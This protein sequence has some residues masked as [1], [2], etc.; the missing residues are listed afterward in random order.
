MASVRPL[1]FPDSAE[2]FE[3]RR[4]AA[5]QSPLQA[6]KFIE[7]MTRS[8]RENHFGGSD[9]QWTE[10]LDKGRSI[11]KLLIDWTHRGPYH[12]VFGNLD[13][14]D[15]EHL[16][17]FGAPTV[18]AGARDALTLEKRAHAT[19]RAHKD[20]FPTSIW[21]CCR[22]FCFTSIAIDPDKILLFEE[23]RLIHE[24]AEQMHESINNESDLLERRERGIGCSTVGYVAPT[25]VRRENVLESQS[26]T[27]SKTALQNFANFVLKVLPFL[28]G[29][30]DAPS[31]TKCPSERLCTQ[32]IC[33]LLSVSRKFLYG[34]KKGLPSTEPSE[35]EL[36]SIVDAAGT[37]LRQHR[38]VGNR[39]GYPSILE[40]P[41]YDCGCSEPC[42]GGLNVV[43]LTNEYR[44]FSRCSQEFNPRRKEN[45]FL[46]NVMF[47]PL[48]MAPTKVCDSALS[49]LYTVSKGHISDVRTALDTMCS[50]PSIEHRAFI[51]GGVE[52]YRKHGMH[53]M[54]R[55]PDHIR[56]KV[57]NHLDMVL[58]AD[59][60]GANGL[61]VCR[62]YSP[63]INTKE[64][65]RTLL[66][67]S[68][69]DDEEVDEQL[70]ESTL[71]RIVDRY[72]ETRKCTIE[73]NQSD[74]NACPNCKTLN[75]AILQFHYETKQL[76]Q[77]LS[78][79]FGMLPRPFDRDLQ[80]KVDAAQSHIETKRFQEREALQEFVEHNERD[81]KI[82]K[83]V[84]VWSDHFRDVENSYRKLNRS[85]NGWNSM[86]DHAVIT[87][88]DDM[89]KV[90][91]PHFVV[92]VT[93]DITRWRFDVDAHVSS[94]TKEAIIF[95]H[96][97]GT[98]SKNASAIIEMIIL[99]HLVRCQGESIKV[100]V[101]DN[102]SVGK[103]WLT[104][105]ALPQYLVDQ[106]LA[107][108]VIV[109]YLEN[110]HGKWLADMLFGQ[111]QTRR[112]RSTLLSVDDL[113]SEFE[114]VK[115]KG[116][117]VYGFAA[118]PL[119]SIEFSAVLESLGYRTK[120]P[121]DFG[122][123]KRNIHFA[124]ACN[125]VAKERL[126]CD[127]KQL[128]G[129]ALPDDD[130]MV[131]LSSSPPTHRRQDALSFEER[132]CDVPA[133]CLSDNDIHTPHESD[134]S[135]PLV[136]PVDK[137]FTTGGQGVVSQR[138]TKHVGFN[139]I[140]FRTAKGY[141]EL[142][143]HSSRLVRQAWPTGL[144]GAYSV[145]DSGEPVYGV[146]SMKSAPENWVIRRPLRHFGSSESDWKA[147]YPPK[148]LLNA[149]FGNGPREEHVWV[150]TKTYDEPPFPILEGK[151]ACD[152]MKNIA[153]EHMDINQS[154]NVLDMLRA[155]F[156]SMGDR[157]GIAD[158][159]LQRR[160]T[161]PSREAVESYRNRMQLFVERGRGEPSAPKTVRQIFKKDEDVGKE[162]TQL[163]LSRGQVPS[164]KT[165]RSKVYAQLFEDA[166][167][168]PG[169]LDR[170]LH[171]V[172]KDH[173][174]YSRELKWF[175]EKR[176]E[177][178]RR[179]GLLPID[180]PSD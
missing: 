27:N 15:S 174:R 124:A 117:Q 131:R 153:Q 63:E 91:L 98:G 22:R 41:S 24:V 127:L 167:N 165:L 13:A 172:E 128:L 4:N 100:V 130:G 101:S 151:A 173:E 122:F 162:V 46:L 28:S 159:W 83:A 84:K 85:G 156:V 72:L 169:G 67:K 17:R 69:D 37:R 48:S 139:G 62:V 1:K 54:N 53:P 94:V 23:L 112:K 164:D 74:H 18:N 102:A 21:N 78:E 105:V 157:D 104:T 103:N 114:A 96:E 89:T 168:K 58:R 77:K 61:N 30:E 6:W 47:S 137:G 163:L 64:K 129:T 25:R 32:A 119:A 93:A 160:V 80:T 36:S 75:Y 158:R 118:N 40:L 38:R 175:K 178:D 123:I 136:V 146:E 49:A 149:K 115:C 177:F 50:N 106:G 60:A 57:E 81:A 2:D 55:Y 111:W 134:V 19:F 43:Y 12:D 176:R 51:E 10:T 9:S 150:P 11:C 16:T 170:F 155:V 109:V 126:G 45:R 26:S 108:I 90:D 154:V 8:D 31:G 35:Q 79:E 71:Q 73:F 135:P 97:Q 88:Q 56:E 116:G 76:Q 52:G 140:E 166:T 29:K 147:R 68:L 107:D 133:S 66:A 113:L 148:N 44:A 3:G 152:A 65:L 20:Y 110:N 39:R 121:K 87:H 142:K 132:Y 5:R 141:P 99:D 59:P 138:T 161:I 86:P 42:L 143:N 179:N 14:H 171:L 120:P 92:N 82:R 144:S 125:P 7:D 70:S 95:S 34:R 145:S 180:I 33:C